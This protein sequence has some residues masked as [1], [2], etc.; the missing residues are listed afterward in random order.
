MED[1]TPA[2]YRTPRFQGKSSTA[3]LQDIEEESTPTVMEAPTIKEA[4]NDI[5]K[6]PIRK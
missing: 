1:R 2:A 4:V 5:V 3:T 6:I